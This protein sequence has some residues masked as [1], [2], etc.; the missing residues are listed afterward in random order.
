MTKSESMLA[1]EDVLLRVKEAAAILACSAST[2]LQL[3]RRQELTPI[4][5][6]TGS[7]GKRYPRSRVLEFIAARSASP[8]SSGPGRPRNKPKGEKK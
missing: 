5:I 1:G 7:R 3:Q 8:P 6:G 2:L 4:Y